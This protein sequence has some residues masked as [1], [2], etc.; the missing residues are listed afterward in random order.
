MLFTAMWPLAVLY[1]LAAQAAVVPGGRRSGPKVD[2][3]GPNDA[4]YL[5]QARD[6]ESTRNPGWT[7]MGC[8]TDSPSRSLDGM[9]LSWSNMTLPICMNECFTRGYS[10]G[11]VQFGVECWVRAFPY[12]VVRLLIIVWFDDQDWNLL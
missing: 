4:L 10:Y 5:Q 2:K 6:A 3:R 12:L 11:G 8:R 1:A 9:Y 7:A